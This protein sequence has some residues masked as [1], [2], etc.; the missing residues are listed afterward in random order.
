V[1]LGVT[2][3][4]QPETGL[5]YA[6]RASVRSTLI[7]DMAAHSVPS[8]FV[9][10]PQR[11][12]VT[13]TTGQLDQD[14]ASIYRRVMLKL[15][16]AERE[17]LD[18]SEDAFVISRRRCGADRA[19]I[20]QSYSRRMQELQAALPQDDGDQRPAMPIPSTRTSG[21]STDRGKAD[22]ERGEAGDAQRSIAERRPPASGSSRAAPR[23]ANPPE[24]RREAKTVTAGPRA[25]S[26][27]QADH[28]KSAAR[29]GG[30]R[31][32]NSRRRAR[33]AGWFDDSGSGVGDPNSPSCS[34]LR[35]VLENQHVRIAVIPA[36]TGGDVPKPDP[37]SAVEEHHA[38]SWRSGSFAHRTLE[39]RASL[40][41]A[42][43]RVAATFSVHPSTAAVCC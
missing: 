37:V 25:P 18:H 8:D 20:E 30:T 6:P 33:I 15:P 28:G 40:S 14:L 42:P 22:G 5:S 1:E 21:V 43:A 11:P 3:T 36:S 32:V 2:A 10:V 27:P 41:A 16:Q 39:P 23:P 26:Q 34:P 29:S 7:A 9:V 13:S 17:E 38:G 35:P 19:C 31:W 12:S 24:K 4:V